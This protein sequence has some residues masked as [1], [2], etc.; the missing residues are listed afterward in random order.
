MGTAFKTWCVILAG[1]A[2]ARFWPVDGDARPKYLLRPEGGETLIEMAWERAL[3]VT[4]LCPGISP[5]AD[6]VNRVSQ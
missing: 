1:G 5:K 6:L 3:S 2:S 4:V